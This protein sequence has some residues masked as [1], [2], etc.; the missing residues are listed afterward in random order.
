MTQRELPTE[1]LLLVFDKMR[2]KK[3]MKGCLLVCKHWNNVLSEVFWNKKTVVVDDKKIPE[4]VQ[5]LK[6]HPLFCTKVNRLSYFSKNTNDSSNFGFIIQ[7][8]CN[9]LK[10]LR[11]A[12]NQSQLT[13]F[14]NIEY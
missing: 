6:V 8:C 11:V 12:S 14:D 2:Y 5:F 4:F 9:K 13:I 1:I 7:A 3:D 10:A